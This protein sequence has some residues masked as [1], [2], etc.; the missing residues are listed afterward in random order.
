MMSHSARLDQL[1][2]AAIQ[3]LVR[4]VDDYRPAVFTSSFSVEDM[5]VLDLIDQAGVDVTVATLD[6]GRLHQ[7]TYELMDRARERYQRPVR[8]YAPRADALEAFVTAEGVNAFYRSI[9]LRKRCCEIRKTEPLAR[10]LADNALWVTGLRRAQSVTRAGLELL[11]RD[12]G[13]GLMKLNPLLD[14]LEEDVW[15]YASLHDVPTNPLHQQGFPSIGCA[16]CT[17]AITV[18]EDPRAGRWWWEDA[19]TR[20]CGLHM[21]PDGRLVRSRPAIV[22]AEG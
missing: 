17:R 15:A 2:E 11:S 7:E 9:E 13:H 22:I 3:A 18:G 19:E 1:T 21:T 10:A 5:V 12:E 6:T 20:E 4:A 14:W 8:V 16:P